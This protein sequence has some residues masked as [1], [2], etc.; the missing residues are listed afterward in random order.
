[1]VLGD[2]LG[3]NSVLGFQE[4][5]SANFFCRI[6][7]TL[8]ETIKSQ[9][10]EDPLMFCSKETYA[11]NSLDLMHDVLEGILRYDMDCILNNLINIRKY[12]TVEN[13]NKAIRYFKFSEAGNPPVPEIKQYHINKKMYY[14]ERLRIAIY[15]FYIFWYIIR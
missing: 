13:M 14:C 7:V 10:K 11:I 9:F 3:L 12:F 6:C 15:F 2:N 4:S 1:M 5:V 8:K